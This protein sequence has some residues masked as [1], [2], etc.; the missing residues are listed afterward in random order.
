M[1]EYAVIPDVIEAVQARMQASPPEAEAYSANLAAM[2]AARGAFSSDDDNDRF[3]TTLAQ[4][5]EEHGAIDEM[6]QG[7]ITV[8]QAVAKNYQGSDDAAVTQL[9]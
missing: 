1:A 8:L 4:I 9:S 5:E 6:Y 3:E 7:V 2:S